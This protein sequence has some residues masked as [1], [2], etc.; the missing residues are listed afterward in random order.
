MFG[1]LYRFPPQPPNKPNVVVVVACVVTSV[2]GEV[3]VAASARDQAVQRWKVPPLAKASC[4]AI[5]IRTAKA[6]AK[7]MPWPF[8]RHFR[9][10][11]G[12]FPMMFPPPKSLSH[13]SA[14]LNTAVFF[15]T[16]LS[17][18]GSFAKFAAIRERPPRNFVS[19]SLSHNHPERISR[20]IPSDS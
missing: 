19:R 10:V 3:T 8:K 16:R 2:R 7:A 5:D 14:G 18:S 13:D 15:S 9:D 12:T 17:S 4:G 20:R 11:T 6:T 1:S